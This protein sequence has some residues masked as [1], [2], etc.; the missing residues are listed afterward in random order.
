MRDGLINHQ[1][2]ENHVL[3]KLSASS[4]YPSNWTNDLNLHKSLNFNIRAIFLPLF[5]FLKGHFQFHYKKIGSRFSAMSPS[6]WLTTRPVARQ[7]LQ[8]TWRSTTELGVT[9]YFHRLTYKSYVI[10][11]KI[12]IRTQAGRQYRIMV[13]TTHWNKSFSFRSRK[14]WRMLCYSNVLIF[15]IR[16]LLQAISLSSWMNTV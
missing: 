13:I 4:I 8:F 10:R 12:C 14:G 5:S 15:E 7:L 3:L 9:L 6:L 11:I 1:S 16:H 2:E